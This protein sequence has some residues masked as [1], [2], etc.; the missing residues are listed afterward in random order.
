MQGECIFFI[1]ILYNNLTKKFAQNLGTT[2][3]NMTSWKQL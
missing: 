3:P 1:L 2:T